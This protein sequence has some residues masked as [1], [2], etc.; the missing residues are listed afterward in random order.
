MSTNDKS[1][2]DTLKQLFQHASARPKAP[3]EDEMAIR[4]ATLEEWHQVIRARRRKRQVVAFAIAASLVLVVTVIINMQSLQ[5]P[6]HAGQQIASIDHWSGQVHVRGRND[7]LGE[8]RAMT[9]TDLQAGH[10]LRTVGDS[11]L[12]LDWMSGESL[13]IDENSELLLVSAKEIRLNYGRVYIDTQ[14]AG[15]SSGT[16]LIET[17]IG[18]IEHIGTQ[19]MTAINDGQLEVTVREGEVRIQ[20]D[21]TVSSAH[22]GERLSI[23]PSG[24]LRRTEMP[25]YGGDWEWVAEVTPA[26][27]LDGVS[28]HSFIQW[29]GRESGR[30]VIYSNEQTRELALETQLRG[31]IDLQ[32]LRALK[33]I[34]LTTDLEAVVEGGDILVVERKGS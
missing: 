12:A 29:A 24:A 6:E 5:R 18:T 2:K 8:Q 25:T 14:N 22:R 23:D 9:D 7:T 17:T 26:F 19:Y 28:A 13:R 15:D 20:A 3:P 4:E 11:R 30:K 31:N 34:L 21:S 10:V 27:G 16:F 1:G 33:L 32:P